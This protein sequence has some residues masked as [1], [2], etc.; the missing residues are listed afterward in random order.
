MAS[1]GSD[2]RP[3][4][5]AIIGAGP[6]GFYAAEALTRGDI[7]TR[8]DMF[9]R[10]PAPYGLVRYGVAPDHAKI[11][12][13]IKV[14]EKTIAKENISFIGN[15]AV[16]KDISVAELKKY[17]DAI[18]F[19][20]GAE[21]D[22][23][24]EIPGI[25]LAG[26]HT[27]T[28]FVAWYNGRP[29]YRDR[30]FNL[31]GEI[32]VIIGQGNVAMD[33]CRIL[34]KSV[35]ELKATDI[36]H[37]ALEALAKSNIK[38]VHMIGRRGPAQ[39]AFTPVEIR[40]FGELADCDAVVKAED[41]KLNEASQKELEDVKNAPKKKNY[42]ILQHLASEGKKGRKKKFV[43]H[44]LKSPVELKGA[45]KVQ[46]LVLEGNELSGTANEQ[47]A[48][49]TGKKEEMR[50]D[51]FFRSVGYSGIPIEGVPFNARSG[52]FDNEAGRIKGEAQL[53]CAGWIKRGPSGVIGTN[54]PDAEETVAHILADMPKLKPCEIP[55]T[56]KLLATVKAKG[57]RVVNFEDWKKI[58]AAEIANGAKAGKPREKFVRVEDMLAVLK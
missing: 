16:G 39:A 40:E 15:V 55:D 20:C 10:L 6:S 38:E 9:D 21:T 33:V 27:A 18:L 34:C 1:L 8:V 2:T 42:E 5:I 23:K 37:H 11:K 12:S 49:G 46:Q 30:Q 45:G 13:V 29:E 31:S 47:K 35:E 36:A 51:L 44:F 19:T 24:L 41:L 14:Y 4:R 28:E 50:C 43:C 22:R 52:T 56:A 58:D 32:A 54:K 57:V 7:K 25:D 53:Y 3:L 17:Y 48:K 26:S